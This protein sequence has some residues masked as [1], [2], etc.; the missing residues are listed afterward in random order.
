LIS[1]TSARALAMA[2]LS[3]TISMD[4]C[5]LIF[6]LF[7]VPHLSRWDRQCILHDLAQ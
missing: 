5:S 6:Y 1:K 4:K 7:Q 3:S 2:G